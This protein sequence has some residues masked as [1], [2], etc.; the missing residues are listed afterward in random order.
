MKLSYV[1]VYILHIY[2]KPHIIYNKY[3][4]I[5]KFHFQNKLCEF[6]FTATLLSLAS[7]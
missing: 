7:G 3:E 1:S 2:Y 5:K 6:F 4:Y